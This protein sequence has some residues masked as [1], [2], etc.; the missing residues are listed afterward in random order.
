MALGASRGRLARGI[1]IE[2]ALLA[3]ASSILALPIAWWLFGL[4]QVFQLPGNVSVELLE[5]SLDMRV[6]AACIVGA[7][8]AVL[9]IAMVVGAF[10][11]RADV[12]G[13]LRARS[14]ATPSGRRRA[15]RAALVA[16]QVAVAVT[17]VAGAG[18]LTRS[19]VAALRLN[20][21]LDMSRI[22]I[23]TIP[24]SEYGYTTPRASEFYETLKT[25]LAASPAVEAVALSRWEG[26]MSPSG[27]LQ[28]DGVAQQFPTLV[29][30]IR[31]DPQFFPTL[32]IRL[33]EGRH[34]GGDDRD[35]SPPVAIV[36]ESLAKLVGGGASPLG[37]RLG[38]FSVEAKPLTIVGVATDVITNVTVMEPLI[39]Y[40]PVAQGAPSMIR[41][42]HVR[43][44]GNTAVA[45]AQIVAAVKQIDPQITMTTLRTLEQRIAEQMAPQRLG[46]TVM[47]ALGVIAVLLTLLGTYVLAES[48]ASSR[49]REMGIR[50]ALGATRRQ[51]GSI[52]LA[53]TLRLAGIGVLLGLGLAWMS[54][55][56]IRSFLFQVE[57]FDP[58]TIGAVSA[59]I[60]VLALAVSLR[61]ALRV[62]HVELAS[63]LRNE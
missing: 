52:V 51:L 23:G 45:K 11:F 21:G 56:T 38:G 42:M 8:A 47:G 50:A 58:T 39:I 55:S 12:A 15:T 59:V 43:A 24:L 30:Y 31:V 3:I 16:A 63:V 28:V 53:E 10:G 7:T 25:R 13:A 35:M 20:P 4:I 14:G 6:L 17:L 29:S 61:A 44:R 22:V 46:A 5:L 9:L 2:G 34:F 57:P 60:L 33:V 49:M 62:A 37:L 32:G 40:L 41:E 1:A 27:K 18:L 26:G 54:T 48:M 19:L 36:S